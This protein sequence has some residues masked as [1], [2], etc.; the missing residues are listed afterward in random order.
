M[1]ILPSFA[2]SGAAS[3]STSKKPARGLLASKSDRVRALAL[4]GSLTPATPTRLKCTSSTARV[5]EN[6]RDLMR[7]TTQL[8][9]SWLRKAKYNIPFR[10][11]FP[12]IFAHSHV[13]VAWIMC[14]IDAMLDPD[15][16]SYFL[17]YSMP[18]VKMPRSFIEVRMISEPGYRCSSIPSAKVP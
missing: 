3:C 7:I 17:H 1:G 15:R 4:S 10:V 13:H 6:R 11:S 18:E 2:S 12:Y 8:P 14:T 5:L 16:C 9:L